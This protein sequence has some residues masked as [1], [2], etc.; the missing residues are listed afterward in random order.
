MFGIF[1]GCCDILPGQSGHS[2]LS[3]AIGQTSCCSRKVRQDKKRYE[4]TTNGDNTFNDEKPSPAS[5]SMYA[6]KAID[7]AR[8]DQSTKGT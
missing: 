5:N 7:N 3:L 1:G 4:S 2:Y 8:S 6:F